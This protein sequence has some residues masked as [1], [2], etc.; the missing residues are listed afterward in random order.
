MSENI[1]SEILLTEYRENRQRIKDMI[2]DLEEHI[3]VVKDLIPK[4]TSD[5][6]KGKIYLENTLKTITEF[7]KLIFDMRKEIGK[8]VKD[9]I[10]IIT[11]LNEG[12]ED[13]DIFKRMKIID[14]FLIEMGV[15]LS[16]LQK[17]KKQRDLLEVNKNE[18][19]V[20]ER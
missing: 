20:D 14:K 9:E 5:F 17:I 18:E 4:G 15:S 3:K 2:V 6:R 12:V 19:D 8:L 1:N 16:D 7:Y 10:A 11:K 13:D